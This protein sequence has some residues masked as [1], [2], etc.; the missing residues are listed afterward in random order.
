MYHSGESYW[1]WRR[2]CTCVLWWEVYEKSLCFPFG[3]FVSLKLLWRKYVFLK[4]VVLDYFLRQLTYFKHQ[5]AVDVAFIKNEWGRWKLI[6]NFMYAFWKSQL[7]QTSIKQALNLKKSPYLIQHYTNASCFKEIW[8][9]L[10]LS[11]LFLYV[12]SWLQK[13][14]SIYWIA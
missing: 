1:R 4:K 8:C 13:F 14:E 7:I 5:V 9:L 3:F 2:L 11:F 6:L 12:F 10:L